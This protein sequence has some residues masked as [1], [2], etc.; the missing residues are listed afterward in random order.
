[1][2]I[3]VI[4]FGTVGRAFA[5]K[6]VGAGHTLKIS[7]R[8]GPDSLRDE[9]A[10]LGPAVSAVTA[11]EAATCPVVLLAVPW[12][13]VV[14]VLSELKAWDGQIL[15]DTLNPFHGRRGSFVLADVGNLSTSQLVAHLAPGARVVKAIN[16]LPMTMFEAAPP[17]GT[18]RVL[19]V[20]GD[21]AD[22]KRT[23][24]RLFEELGFHPVD[25]G[26]LRDGGLLQQVGGPLAAKPFLI[27]S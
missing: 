13:D 26:N 25:L 8:R 6:A 1:M 19:F 4:G 23:A 7:N 16:T 11:R 2:E 22:A 9:A 5:T 17:P 27:E 24:S 20:S 12:D 14:G 10:A 3:G 21:D 18:K 15:V